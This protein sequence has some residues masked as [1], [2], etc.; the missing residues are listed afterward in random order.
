M[1]KFAL[2]NSS[3]VVEHIV[4]VGTLLERHR[5]VDDDV[6]CTEDVDGDLLHIWQRLELDV[7]RRVLFGRERNLEHLVALEPLDNLVLVDKVVE[8]KVAVDHQNTRPGVRDGRRPL[9]DQIEDGLDLEHH[10]VTLKDVRAASHVDTAIRKDLDA[11][12][13]VAVHIRQRHL[14][15]E[16]CVLA[17][18]LV[19]ASLALHL[20]LTT[21]V[22][23]S[24]NS[25][26]TRRRRHP[27]PLEDTERLFNSLHVKF[28]VKLGEHC[29]GGQL[30]PGRPDVFRYGRPK[31][32]HGHDKLGSL[33]ESHLYLFFIS[34]LSP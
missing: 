12:V 13:R 11:L 28:A 15:V 32:V 6:T 29:D 1:S 16:G 21:L 33:L 30:D 17:A 23:D 18:P 4:G 9:E 8:R 19:A 24:P 27:Y 3:K 22:D 34:P 5:P 31:L 10:I 25:N 26:R 14:V 2:I 7:D 20:H